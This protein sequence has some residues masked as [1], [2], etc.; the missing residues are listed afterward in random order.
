M[1][2]KFVETDFARAERL[3]RE[4]DEMVEQN[5]A[6]RAQLE[7]LVAKRERKIVELQA[8]LVFVCD[9]AKSIHFYRQCDGRETPFCMCGG[10]PNPLY[11]PDLIE[12]FTG[13]RKVTEG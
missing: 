6:D 1:P 13:R 5:H 4:L 2:D 7:E 9:P 12:K 10:T 8:K 11:T 3:A